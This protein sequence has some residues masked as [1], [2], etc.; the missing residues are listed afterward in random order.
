M[1]VILGEGSWSDSAKAAM[2]ALHE[3]GGLY[4]CIHLG[5][6]PMRI[7]VL[8]RAFRSAEHKPPRSG[9]LGDWSDIARGRA[10]ALDY[11]RSICCGDLGYPLIYC[12]TQTETSDGQAGDQIYRPGS[13]SKAGRRTDL[14]LYTWNGREFVNRSRNEPY[15]C[16]MVQVDHS[17]SLAPLINFHWQRM[18]SLAGFD[19]QIEPLVVG[20]VRERLV[21]VL[22]CLLDDAI[23]CSN[24][25]RAFREIIS[26]CATPDG[27]VK[28]AE[29]Q[30][31]QGQIRLNDQVYSGVREVAI[32]AAAIFDI[33]RSSYEH[34]CKMRAA[35]PITPQLSTA[36]VELFS[37]LFIREPIVRL[38][39]PGLASSVAVHAHWGARHMAGYPPRKHGYFSQKATK[40]TVRRLARVIASN[41]GG[42]PAL[43]HLLAPAAIFMLCPSEA[44]PNDADLLSRLFRLVASASSANGDGD[45]I[46]QLVGEWW[47]SARSGISP[48]FKTRFGR[49]IDVPDLSMGGRSVELDDFGSLSVREACAIVGALVDL[50][51][52]E[53]GE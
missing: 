40:K 12:F 2:A 11:N 24:P 28:A 1:N 15:F 41:F 20:E 16:P 46:E 4:D 52:R 51:S 35:R 25:E 47:L 45:A 30:L 10:G 5:T 44:F 21:E 19:F 7:D 34:S 33:P 43:C 42:L 22:C 9:H 32:E 8:T 23:C 37:C 13:I 17:G 49:S 48:Y 39:V 3:V 38:Q 29:V 53:T 31:G 26:H 36:F 14:N 6:Q 50:C 27:R 18:G